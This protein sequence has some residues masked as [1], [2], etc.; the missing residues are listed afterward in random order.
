[1]RH[2]SGFDRP[3]LALLAL[4]G[5]FAL[6][7]AEYTF[8]FSH[9]LR[10]LLNV[11]VYNNVMIAAGVLCVL[12]GVLHRRERA[13]WLAMGAAVLAWGVGNTIW[14]FTV[15]GLANPPYP[16]TAD[17]F[18]LAVY[19]PAYVALVL[20]IR[21]QLGQSRSSL[22][23]DG[24]IASL[25]V[26]AVGSAVVFQS[27]L[28]SLGGSRAAIATNLAYPLADLTLIGMVVWGLALTGWRPDRRWRL[29]AAGL[30]VFAVS[31]C[32]YLYE[33]AV[34]S[35][36]NGSP[37][38]LGWVAGGLLLGWAAWLP[39][40]PRPAVTLDGWA[41]QLAPVGFGLIALGVLVY[42]HFERVNA[43]ALVLSALC[44]LA[45]VG[46]MALAFRDN[47]RM[48]AHSRDEA[49]TDELTGL[50]NRRRLLRDL[51]HAVADRRS[52]LLA[53]FDLNG[54]KQYNDL[55][56]HPAGDALL[57]RLGADLA[58]VV[59]APGEAYRMGGDEF[60]VL[61]GRGA[62]S[63]LVLAGA[64]RA[65]AEAGDGFAITASYG[66]VL[67]P[68]EA[69]T[70]ADALRLADQRM[71]AQKLGGRVSASEQSSSVLLRALAEGDPR[72]GRHV[73]GVAE[74]AEAV[75]NELGLT[76]LEVAR[77]R[78]AAELHDI[79]KLAIPDAILEK[80]AALSGGEWDFVRTHTEIGERILRAAPALAHVASVIRST[81]E[82]YDGT[83]YPDGLAGEEI[84]LSAR[85][86]FVCDAYDAMTSPRPYR[87]PLST[88]AAIHELRRCAGTQFDPAVVDACAGVLER[89]G[90]T[91]VALAG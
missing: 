87:R 91:A 35:Y 43:L 36:K 52:A 24:V 9:S 71:Y 66:A 75:A 61:L 31:D 88:V 83:G 21:S 90:A 81:H 68:A 73:E 69:D 64:R 86:V 76:E 79:G 29:I 82:N 89:R 46:R 32:L 26:G 62:A 49:E 54:F 13:A 80:P 10:H 15:A 6:L 50:G 56:G 48:L 34:G 4:T 14:T 23:L 33:T 2:L 84:P 63:E 41:L 85:I 28:G 58:A 16:S 42:D 44:V 51:E 39:A 25:A 40:R 67:L 74:L 7:A 47:A 12:R 37:T 38:D 45:V 55:F 60:C 8:Q 70:V 11:A 3:K 59:P 18:F 20:L 57:S 1:M 65:L 53:L 17:F 30:L 78:L 77:V 72:L 19:P 22:W 27:V 5:V